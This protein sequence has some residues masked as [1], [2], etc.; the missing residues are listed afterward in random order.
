MNLQCGY[1]LC[2]NESMKGWNLVKLNLLNFPQR[3]VE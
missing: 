3:A 1:G 2:E